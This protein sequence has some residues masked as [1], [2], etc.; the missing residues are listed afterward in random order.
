MSK[1]DPLR[2]KLIANS[3][4]SLKMPFAEIF[5]E[6]EVLIGRSLPNSAY[7]YDAW[8]ATKTRVRQHIA[9]AE[10][11]TTAGYDAEVQRLQRMVTFRRKR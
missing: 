5:A 4:Q 8:W 7:E 3:S 1:Y 9:I 6:I 2:D 11:W 10:H